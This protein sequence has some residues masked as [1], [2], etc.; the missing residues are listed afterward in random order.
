MKNISAFFCEIKNEKF[1]ERKIENCEIQNF[2]FF[3][4]PYDF[5]MIFRDENFHDIF[6]FFLKNVWT[7]DFK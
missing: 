2:D 4:F 6:G 3:D 5:S 7:S 1:R